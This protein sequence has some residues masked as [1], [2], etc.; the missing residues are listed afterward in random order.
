MSDKKQT[1]K[2]AKKQAKKTVARAARRM[3]LI[4]FSPYLRSL[5]DPINE[6]G[7]KIPDTQTAPS[8]VVH[9]VQ[10]L[11]VTLATAGAGPIAAGIFMQL[12]D[13]RTVAGNCNNSTWT[14]GAAA[15]QL[16]GI[17][18]EKSYAATV[19]SIAQS[20][21]P[22]S[23][24][25]YMAYQ[26]SPLNAKGRVTVALI[27]PTQV[28]QTLPPVDVNAD[29][30]TLP[31]LSTL[32]ANVG[33]AEVKYLPIDP[34]SKSYCITSAGRI[35]PFVRGSAAVFAATYGAL[36]ILLDGG[37]AGDIVEFTIVE[38]FECLPQLQA[39]NLSSPTPSKSDPIE[40]A[41][42]DN[43]I[44]SKPNLAVTQDLASTQARTAVTQNQSALTPVSHDPKKHESGLM[45][46]VLKALGVGLDF[47]VGAAPK[48]AKL[49]SIAA[50][51]LL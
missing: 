19:S 8:F 37:T 51:L 12:A 23:A 6:W 46:S 39:T 10:R 7:A 24:A 20:L 49:A 5:L 4:D 43:L 31:Y 41:A 38:N 3:G 18:F 14:G 36:Y 16:A 27:P 25:V 50:P 30:Q 26:G 22:V 13:L 9:C 29:V 35:A 1:K 28:P 11:Q 33:F 47:A 44:S 32:P 45:D 15:S 42:V 21:R 48:V 40:M 17:N 2:T 34:L